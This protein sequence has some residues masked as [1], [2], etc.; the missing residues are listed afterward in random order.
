MRAKT[1]IVSQV[2]HLSINLKFNNSYSVHVYL[3]WVS[4][5]DKS[6]VPLVSSMNLIT[7]MLLLVSLHVVCKCAVHACALPK[8][9]YYHLSHTFKAPSRCSS[10]KSLIQ[11]CDI[12][13]NKWGHHTRFQMLSPKVYKL[14]CGQRK[15]M[16]FGNNNKEIL[17]LLGKTYRKQFSLNWDMEA[18]EAFSLIFLFYFLHLHHQSFCCLVFLFLIIFVFLSYPVVISLI[19]FPIFLMFVSSIYSLD[20]SFLPDISF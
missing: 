6:V 20:L 15:T 4:L 17:V 14:K 5:E 18:F 2:H 16:G 19:S 12:L 9:Y 11:S 3:Q 13:L 10:I 1:H 8:K 7:N